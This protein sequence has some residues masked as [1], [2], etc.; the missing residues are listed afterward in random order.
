MVT[1]TSKAAQSASL[2]IFSKLLCGSAGRVVVS[3]TTD[4]W[5]ESSHFLSTKLKTRNLRREGP[6]MAQF[7][8]LG[9]Y[10][11]LFISLSLIP[12]VLCFLIFLVHHTVIFCLVIFLHFS[13]F[14]RSIKTTQSNY[15]TLSFQLSLFPVSITLSFFLLSTFNISSTFS[16]FFLSRRNSI[17]VSHVPIHSY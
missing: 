11:T 1:G 9:S 7:L 6:G 4:S 14:Y 13:N 12:V 15:L 16:S 2:F 5:F 8:P 3:N 17:I 10:F